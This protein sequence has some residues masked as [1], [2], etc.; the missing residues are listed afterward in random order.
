LGGE[1]KKKQKNITAGIRLCEVRNE[2]TRMHE[3]YAQIHGE[4][5][6]NVPIDSI[7]QKQWNGYGKIVVA[8]LS[9]FEPEQL[10]KPSLEKASLVYTMAYEQ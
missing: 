9:R 6:G 8:A 3:V 7:T 4:D 1:T 5:K 10:Q 2:N